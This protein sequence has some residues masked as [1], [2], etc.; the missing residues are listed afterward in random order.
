MH[1]R[2]AWN[3][4]WNS[5]V[6]QSVEQWAESECLAGCHPTL[7]PIPYQYT[8]P[9]TIPPSIRWYY[10]ILRHTLCQM[11][12]H[13][14]TASDT[15][16][17]DEYDEPLDPVIGERIAYIVPLPDPVSGPTTLLTY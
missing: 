6:E 8:I 12:Q 7:I 10:S 2:G 1:H 17:C 15:D 3:N 4:P 16:Q 14:S 9:Y 5:D 13:Q 11:V